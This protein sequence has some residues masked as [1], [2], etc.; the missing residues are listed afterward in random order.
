MGITLERGRFVTP[1]DNETASV[2]IDIDYAFVHIYLR[3]MANQLFGFG[4]QDPL[5]LAL[6]AI[7]LTLAALVAATAQLDAP[8][9]VDPTA[10]LSY[11]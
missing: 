5:T 4:A 3:L 7:V 2:V 8:V 1:Q 9:R 10:A 6:V 11:E